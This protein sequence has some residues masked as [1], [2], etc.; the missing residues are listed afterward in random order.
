VEYETFPFAQIIFR[1]ML[2]FYIQK[3]Q[4]WC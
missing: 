1:Y 2:F 4:K 3:Q